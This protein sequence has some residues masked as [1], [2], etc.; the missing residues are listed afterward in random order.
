[1]A[2]PMD[3]ARAQ[4][5]VTGSWW[6]D[7]DAPAVPEP[8]PNEKGIIR[9]RPFSVS[10]EWPDAWDLTRRVLLA[11]ASAVEQGKTVGDTDESNWLTYGV[12][13][14]SQLVGAVTLGAGML[15]ELGTRIRAAVDSGEPVLIP[16]WLAEQ[17]AGLAPEELPAVVA[18]QLAQRMIAESEQAP[19]VAARAYGMLTI[20]AALV[21]DP[22]EFGDLVNPS[23]EPEWLVPGVQDACIAVAVACAGIG[24][25]KELEPSHVVAET[26]YVWTGEQAAELLRAVPVQEHLDKGKPQG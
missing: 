25:G 10:L 20:R 8:E 3:V 2:N 18:E 15:T 6:G 24:Y 21:N 12:T 16:D 7:P 22:R 17:G 1:M 13:Y 4:Y 14:L 11:D 19:E 23:A 9:R 5:P 26:Q